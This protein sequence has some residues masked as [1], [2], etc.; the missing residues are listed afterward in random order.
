MKVVSFLTACVYLWFLAKPAVIIVDYSLHTADITEQF[1][2]N[3]ADASLQ[4]NGQCYLLKKLKEHGTPTTSSNSADK[5]SDKKHPSDK[6]AKD[7]ELNDAFEF[8]WAAH[9]ALP[10][11]AAYPQEFRVLPAHLSIVIPPP[12][13]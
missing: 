5:Q 10:L 6:K 11:I 13:A 2:E 1:C 8:H 12:R 7:H 4:C 3:K 9:T